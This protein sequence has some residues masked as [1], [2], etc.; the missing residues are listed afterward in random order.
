M[1]KHS[2]LIMAH[3]N[4]YTLEKLLIMLDDPRN[5]IFIHID[6][7]TRDFDFDYF[8]EVCKFSVVRYT[9]KRIS[10]QWGTQS[11]VLTE[12]LLFDTAHQYGPYHY[13]HLISGV[14]LPIKSQDY[15]HSFLEQQ[16]KSFTYFDEKPSIWDYQRV[17]IYHLSS[18]SGNRLLQIL[19]SKLVSFQVRY[20]MD[21]VKKTGLTIKK[22]SNWAS[23][24]QDAV[25]ILLRN[26]KRIKKLTRFSVC[27]DEVYKQTILFSEGCDIV[28]S[29]LRFIDWSKEGNHP[30][31]FRISDYDRLVHSDRLFARKFDENVD[32]DIIDKIFAY[33]MESQG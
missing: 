28:P 15:I 33:I 32:R 17:S 24:T 29:D 1:D 27:A 7:K 9:L 20:H 6:K 10:V 13:Y 22:G 23:L 25:E 8:K 26:Q 21:R 2:Y 5:D 12:L 11:Q 3:N 19:G 4:W 18:R 31:V 14:D 16:A 30:C